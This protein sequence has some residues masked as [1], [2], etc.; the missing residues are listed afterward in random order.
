MQKP[1]NEGLFAPDTSSQGRLY[2]FP[3]ALFDPDAWRR[4]FGTLD[5]EARQ[6]GF[7]IMADKKGLSRYSAD[8]RR[9]LAPTSFR[10]A[11]PMEYTLRRYTSEKAQ[12]ADQAGHALE[13]W[14]VATDRLS[15]T[16]Q[17]EFTDRMER[18]TP[19]PTPE[20]QKVA[21]TLRGLLDDWAEKVQSLGKGYLA[22]AI[23]NYM[24][25]IWGNYAEWAARRENSLTPTE[26]QDIASARLARKQPLRGSGSFLKQRSF[27]TQLEGIQAGL[28]PVTHNPVDLQMMKIHEMQKFYYGTRLADQIKQSRMATWIAATAEAEADARL[29]GWQPL[30]DTIFKPRIMGQNNEAGFGRLEPGNYWAPEPIARVFNNYMSQGWAGRSPIYDAIRA[31]N[32]ALNTMQLG[33]SG[34]HATFVTADTTISK[35]ALGLQQL[36]RGHPIRGLGNIALGS[37]P[38][39]P[40]TVAQTALRGGALRRA[41][42]NP[43]NLSPDMARILDALKTGGG[44]AAQSR[45]YQ[46]GASGA[47]FKSIADFK[48]PLSPFY[49]TA[50]D[51]QDAKG[52]YE[53]AVMVPM[54]LAGRLLDT[55]QQPLMGALVPRVKLGVF[56]DMASDWLRDHPDATTEETSAAM[57]KFW[58]S[59]ENRLGQLNYDNLFW[60]KTAKDLAFITTRSVGWN[61]G[62]IREIG[63]AFVDSGSALKAIAHG[64]APQ[65]T[66]RMA[67]SMAL[68]VVT[69]QIGAILTY[70]ATGQGPQSMLDYFYPPTGGQDQGGRQD[71]R[72]IPGYMKDVIAFGHDPQGTMLNKTAPMLEALNELRTNRDYY[73]GIIYD[74]ERDKG[75]AQAYGDFLIN[76]AT[77]FSFR[78]Y[79]RLQGE[80]APGLDQAL[81]FWGFQA[82]PKSITEPQRGEAFQQRQN[83][84]AYRARNKEPGHISILNAP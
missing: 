72:S 2:S 11:K 14:R 17:D 50:R 57:T 62:T 15:P 16:A 63:G 52:P 22:N 13:R 25:H 32:N 56:H 43:E 83:L 29:N 9:G 27:P 61:L 37:A 70:L 53:K 5:R 1:A 75:P 71:R 21:D 45:I 78:S 58:D 77:P 4:M 36:S 41:W 68:P 76:Q 23:E 40:F 48:N 34:F 39:A 64:K 47:F 7:E 31:G 6:P 12:A 26:M 67:Y 82:A 8:I 59:V 28:E 44:T 18:G 54:K 51:F 19:Q 69:A 55:V 42:L 24:G 80:G 3:G 20:L 35:M 66:T 33:A 46:T 49:Q 30:D 60:S 10:G 38:L 81:S 73:G 79:N 74:P 84:K 65:L